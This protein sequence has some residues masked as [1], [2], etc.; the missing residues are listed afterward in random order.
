MN[1]NI[2]RHRLQLILQDERLQQLRTEL[3][4]GTAFGEANLDVS[5]VEAN[6]IP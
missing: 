5:V 1:T 3:K 6:P 2:L 4:P